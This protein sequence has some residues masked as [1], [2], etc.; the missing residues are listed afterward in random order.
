MAVVL[1]HGVADTYRVWD[2]LRPFLGG[3]EVETLALPGFDAEMPEGFHPDKQGYVDW[4]I[5]RLEAFDDPVD[6]VGHDWG[7]MLALRVASLRPDLV[8]TVASGNG[9]VSQDFEW[10]SLA[11]IWQT[12]EAGEAFMRELSAEKLT[13]MLKSLGVDGEAAESAA[14]HVDERMKDCI[15][16]LYRSALHVGEEWQPGLARMYVPTLIYWGRQD[17]ECPVNLAYQMAETIPSARLV[18]LE[19][20]HWV[21][22]ALP[23]ELALSLQQFWSSPYATAR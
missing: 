23:R 20:G 13:A 8:R 11:K 15:L 2:R 14:S 18:E 22:L 6:L 12:P 7:G 1:V 21:Q 9:P 19:C 10:H 5:C 3:S 4:I 16:K 17:H